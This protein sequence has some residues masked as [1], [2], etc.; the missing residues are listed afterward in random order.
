VEQRQLLAA[1]DPILGV[2]ERAFLELYNH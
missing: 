2:V 1:V